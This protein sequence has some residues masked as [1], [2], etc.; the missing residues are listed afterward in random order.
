MSEETHQA[1][2]DANRANDTAKESDRIVISQSLITH[3][4]LSAV[5]TLC[6]AILAVLGFF[7]K[8]GWVQL[9]E[10]HNAVLLHGAALEHM[11]NHLDRLDYKVGLLQSNIFY[12]DFDVITQT[13]NGTVSRTP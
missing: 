13:N 3:C 1:H 10:T 12:K 7:G 9:K 2:V 6:L 4:L 5:G 8:E 11:S